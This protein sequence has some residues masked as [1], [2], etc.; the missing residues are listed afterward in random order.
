MALAAVV[1][2][3][4]SEFPVGVP[5]DR[6]VRRALVVGVVDGALFEVVERGAALALDST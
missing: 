1:L 6:G 4:E 2:T 5:E 3:F